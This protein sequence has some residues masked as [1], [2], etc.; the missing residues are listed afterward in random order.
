MLYTNTRRPILSLIED[1]TPGGHDTLCAACDPQRYQ[2]LGC[3]T[4][5]DNCTANLAA[6]LFD[7]GLRV[8]TT[9]CP[10]NLFMN[11]PVTTTGEMVWSLPNC[12]VGDFVTFKAELDCVVV[13]SACPMD[14]TGNPINGLGPVRDAHF[15]VLDP[16]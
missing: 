14:V 1:T 11:I 6:A 7:L 12:K 15:E 13:F 3:V 2:T 9:P 4:P 8:P 10:L 16:I 5:H